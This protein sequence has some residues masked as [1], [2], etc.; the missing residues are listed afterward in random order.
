MEQRLPTIDE[1]LLP[2]FSK[3]YWDS[4]GIKRKRV[5]RVDE[6][7]REY[8]ETE[9]NAFLGPY[10]Q[11][12]LAAEREFNSNNAVCRVMSADTRHSRSG[13]SATANSRTSSNRDSRSSRSTRAARC[14]CG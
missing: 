10:G 1:V 14:H 8:L 9:S 6:L 3:R 2:F 5:T 12:I 7:L 11:A 13:R 4:T